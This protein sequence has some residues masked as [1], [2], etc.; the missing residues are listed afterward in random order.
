MMEPL[1]RN[2]D[3]LKTHSHNIE[4]RINASHVILGLIALYV[5]V[6]FDPLT[7]EGRT[8]NTADSR[9]RNN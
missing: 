3:G 9:G 7:S 2:I 5:I 8:H 1:P 4:W 6:R